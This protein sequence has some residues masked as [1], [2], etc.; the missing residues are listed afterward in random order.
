MADIYFENIFKEIRSVMMRFLV[1]M[2]KKIGLHQ[3]P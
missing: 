3:K 1:F 2:E